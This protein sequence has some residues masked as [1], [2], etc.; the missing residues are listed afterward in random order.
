[1][2]ELAAES[3]EDLIERFEK[4]NSYSE[5]TV[6]LS[7]QLQRQT[8]LGLSLFFG[9]MRWIY[10]ARDE[11]KYKRFIFA[12][13]QM[14]HKLLETEM[15]QLRTELRLA[16]EHGMMSREERVRL[17][18]LA[19]EFLSERL[20]LFVG[21]LKA[22]TPL[23]ILWVET[24]EKVR[25]AEERLPLTQPYRFQFDFG[26]RPLEFVTEQPV[27]A[28][29]HAEFKMLSSLLSLSGFSWLRNFGVLLSIES[30]SEDPRFKEHASQVL[31]DFLRSLKPGEAGSVDPWTHL[32]QIVPE[33]ESEEDLILIDDGLAIVEKKL[34]AAMKSPL[35]QTRQT[36]FGLID[37]KIQA[38]RKSIQ[39][40]RA[41]VR[42]SFLK[43]VPLSDVDT[44]KKIEKEI[45][46]LGRPNYLE[47]V[48]RGGSAERRRVQVFNPA[49]L[50]IASWP[51]GEF[52]TPKGD[53]KNESLLSDLLL[54]E[55]EAYLK[56]LIH[57]D[58]EIGETRVSLTQ[59]S[60]AEGTP[61]FDINFSFPENPPELEDGI[62][63][64]V[65]GVEHR[66]FHE[67]FLSWYPLLYVQHALPV[68]AEMDLSA[69][70]LEKVGETNDRASYR[71]AA[72]ERIGETAY[73]IRDELALNKSTE[74][75]AIRV[76]ELLGL[77]S[78]DFTKSGESFQK[79]EPLWTGRSYP[80]YGMAILQAHAL[81]LVKIMAHVYGQ[82]SG[83]KSE[84]RLMQQE[85]DAAAEEQTNFQ[86][87]LTPPST[88]YQ[89]RGRNLDYAVSD[90]LRTKSADERVKLVDLGIGYPPFTTI[91][92][93]QKF[94]D[95]LDVLGVD[96]NLPD[97][98]LMIPSIG[99]RQYLL[100]YEVDSDKLQ[101]HRLTY[102][103][104]QRQTDSGTLRYT[105]VTNF[106][107]RQSVRGRA[108]SLRQQIF[109]K[110]SL[111][112]FN[113]HVSLAREPQD[114]ALADLRVYANQR[115]FRLPGGSLDFAPA[116]LSAAEFKNLKFIK[117]GFDLAGIDPVGII[118]A[119]NVFRYYSAREVQA[120]LKQFELKLV[121]GGV[122]I[123]ARDD[124][125]F[126]LF[127]K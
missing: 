41:E 78:Q 85:A 17:A 103:V 89:G 101:T 91:Q 73:L 120:A 49:G 107:E 55:A 39:L 64:D 50:R 65:A 74:D 87:R 71:Q 111:D 24:L 99:G 48:M 109:A 59:R 1:N 52:S 102:M 16:S 84:V 123:A 106:A 40:Q 42:A 124:N 121:E 95:R 44:I 36:A 81:P 100:F 45:W 90:Y 79:D 5:D 34:T 110:V 14:S 22:T 15:H 7:S 75:I 20:D 113:Q 82:S 21:I 8:S 51:V 126:I 2:F 93:A 53:R 118:R 127:Q 38:V 125:N 68:V 30:R 70:R 58:M 46:R 12:V 92:T 105:E 31:D 83:A 116:R 72:L 11:H 19:P 86:G 37:A 94:Q 96:L 119:G 117:G 97:Y 32:E 77:A 28:P 114:T 29:Q 54:D 47:D 3:L 76:A 9:L 10:W 13:N 60:D 23:F 35:D 108:E 66:P 112:D 69:R 6:P 26:N 4:W 25:P 18:A 33:I 62:F 98:V 43:N 63:S 57:P 104:L 27:F 80:D 88:D 56:D 67:L 122:A 115:G 61:W